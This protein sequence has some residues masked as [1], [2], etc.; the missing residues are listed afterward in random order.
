MDRLERA[1]GHVF[2]RPELLDQALTHRSAGAVNN[3][4]LEFLG[5]A[6]IGLL[7]AEALWERFPQADE[8]TLSR[9]RASLVKRESLA[10]LARGLNLGDALRL[11][12]GE[13]RTGGYARDSILADAM[14]A[15]LGAVYLDAGFETTRGLVRR[16][17]AAGI[18]QTSLERSGKDPKTRLQ[19]WLQAR[20]RPLPEYQ[21]V[22]TGGDQHAQTFIVTC[23][24]ND[25]DLITQADGTTRRRAEQGA[26]QAMLEQLDDV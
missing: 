24:L 12:T 1:V 20:H 21:V 3:E 14:E 9:L 22:A 19:E 13:V 26:A 2:A 17:F 15:L 10:A 5:D 4:R 6:L 7:I 8:G 23:T 11:G 18:G 16:L 25:V